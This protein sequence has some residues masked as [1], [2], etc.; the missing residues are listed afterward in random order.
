VVNG[1][2][3]IAP[4]MDDEVLGCAGLI[5]RLRTHDCPTTVVFATEAEEDVRFVGG[6]YVGYTNAKRTGEMEQVAELLGFEYVQLGM[7][8]HRLDQEP[9]GLLVARLED[10]LRDAELVAYPVVSHDQ[11]HEALRTAVG[12]LARPHRFAGTL[13]EYR[14]WGVPGEYDDALIVPLTQEEAK[15]KFD[16]IGLYFSQVRPGGRYDEFYPYAPASVK[17]Y[18][19]AAGRLVHTEYAETFRPRR[20]VPNSTTA[21]LV[22]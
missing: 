18:M 7:Q 13:L 3:V 19:Q 11:D 1:A 2:L 15:S 17:A 5:Q 12:V 22:A 16:A 10:W 8:L 20:I 14:T 9:T 6:E 21:A 4:H